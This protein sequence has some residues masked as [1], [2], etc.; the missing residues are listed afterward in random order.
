MRN[1]KKVISSVAAFAM[2]ASSATA[3]AAT[4]PD[5][6]AS[7][8]YAGAVESLVALGIVNGDDQGLFNPDNNVT[9]AE[10]TKMAVGALGEI[11]AAE[12]QTTSRFEDAA[13]TSVHWAAGYVAQGVSDGFINGY[14][15]KRFGPD[16]KVTYAQAC[17]MLVASLG[18]TTYADNAGG[19]PAGYVAQANSL[20]V[21]KGVSATN[22]T[23]LTRAQCA[24]LIYNAMD[25]PLCVVDSWDTVATFD[26]GTKQVPVL[27][28]LD[29]FSKSAGDYQTL[30]TD[31]HDAYRVKGRVENNSKSN[32]GYEANE[33]DY[34]VEIADNFDDNEYGSGKNA[35]A[36]E[37]FSQMKDDTGKA[38][39]MLFE[40][41][42][43]LI[44]KDVDADEFHIIAITQYGSSKIVEV[45]ADDVSDDPADTTL[46]I[47]G[48]IGVFKNSSS[49]STTKYDLSKEDFT[50]Y[51]NG[52]EYTGTIQDAFDN[53]VYGNTMGT[54][55][56]VDVTNTGSTTTD[57][58]YEYAMITYYVDAVV[59]ST[60]ITSS[61]NKI[62]FKDGG[63]VSTN[64]IKS[65]LAYDPEDENKHISIKTKDGVAVAFEDLKEYDVMSILYDVA[66]GK[67]V[68]DSDF[69]DMIISESSVQGTVTS[70]LTD[71]D[72]NY[73]RIDGSD[74]AFFNKTYKAQELCELNTEYTFYL[75]A[76]G[77]VAMVDEGS[78]DKNYGIVVGMYM[79]NGD[80]QAT[81]RLITSDAKIATY[82]CKD[83]AAENYFISVLTNNAVKTYDGKTYTKST[84]A[85]NI[86]KGLTTVEYQLTSGKIRQKTSSATLKK[87][88]WKTAEYKASTSKLGSYTIAEGVTKLIDIEDYIGGSDTTVGTVAVSSLVDENEYSFVL[89]D[90]NKN[91][92][93]YRLG[94]ISGGM[95]SLRDDQEIAVVMKAEGTTDVD[96][97]TVNKYIV[98]K[99]GQDGIE[100]LFAEDIV[101]YEGDVVSYVVGKDGYVDD[102]YVVVFSVAN[103]YKAMFDGIKDYK[104]TFAAKSGL[105]KN[106]EENSW[107]HRMKAKDGYTAISTSKPAYIF[108][109]PVYKKVN[110]NLEM[111]TYTETAGEFNVNSIESLSVAGANSYVYDFSAR[112]KNH[113]SV[114]AQSQNTSIYPAAV[115][116]DADKSIISISAADAEGVKPAFA[117]VK[118]VDGNVI[119][120]LYLIAE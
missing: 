66:N 46:S 110:N 1:L 120:V 2:V 24:M 31:R 23:A 114:G 42:E 33:V 38:S 37:K 83:S 105:F 69:I 97:E 72:D 84:Y 52:T 119:D 63:S 75:D 56:L 104:G 92:G 76:F 26:G 50:V 60:Q 53:Y 94:L 91:T 57:G 14:D 48:R 4:F 29:G 117:L 116:T 7:A 113:V 89:I 16:D 35:K 3:F 103:D 47:G 5:V 64:A 28:K 106:F 112:S 32:S 87:T 109:G 54:V 55:K 107:G 99:G 67:A 36:A 90:Q 44:K 9:R 20:G 70:R 61:S 85:E 17:K 73:A 65:S 8:S 118:E 81:V 43:A 93:D 6:D 19:Y 45:N 96:G 34:N 59:D 71:D 74:Y 25:V 40:Y 30:L 39:D 88:D 68:E 11:E 79:G 22:D 62:Y 98:A 101:L 41:S 10:F 15:D 21:T 100:V 27:K 78:S 108:Y 80:D 18:Y 12:A 51:V 95:S 111:F 58:K 82:E 102:K 115:Y 86:K 49:T 77:Y 13:N